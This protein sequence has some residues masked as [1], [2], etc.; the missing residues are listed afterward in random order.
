MIAHGSGRPCY[1][2]AVKGVLPDEIR[3]LFWDVDPASVDVVDHRDYVMERV[4]GR[5][6]MAAMRW[7]RRTYSASELA[8][9]LQA[10]GH[11]LAPREQAYWS[12]IARVSL[13]ARR[14]GGRPPWAGP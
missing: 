12:L 11:R 10:K 1:A 5:G 8:V 9:F 14:G 13:P 2:I 3:P 6:G 4:M 7:L